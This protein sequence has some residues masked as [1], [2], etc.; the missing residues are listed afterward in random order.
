MRARLRKVG[1]RDSVYAF[2]AFVWGFTFIV[3]YRTLLDEYYPFYRSYFPL[4]QFALVIFAVAFVSAALYRQQQTHHTRR[5]VFS[6]ITTA[7]GLSLIFVAYH[8]FGPQNALLIFPVP[9]SFISLFIWYELSRY[10]FF[11]QS[12]KIFLISG[13]LVALYAARY[14]EHPYIAPALAFLS[15][16]LA[17]FQ[18]PRKWETPH[19]RLVNL[20][21]LIDLLRY[22]FLAHA[23][24]AA[25]GQNRSHLLLVML[26][27]AIGLVIPQLI[28]LFQASRP[29]IQNGLLILPTIFIVLAALFNFIHYSYWGAVAYAGLAI[30][31]SI[32]FLKAHEVYLRREKLVAGFAL[33]M[34]IMAYYIATEWLQIISGAFIVFVLSG[35]LIYVAK[36]W[37]KAITA[38]FA[39]A[40]LTWI[41]SVQWKY[42]NSV[43]REFLKPPVVQTHKPVLPDSGLL[44]TILG[45]QKATGRSVFTNV[46]PDELLDGPAWKNEKIVSRDANPTLLVSQLAYS[47]YLRKRNR[48]YI[49]DEK[50]LGVYSEPGALVQLR[51]LLEKFGNCD[52]YVA[53]KGTLRSVKNLS[54]I[55]Q[56]DPRLV[57]NLT[58]DDAAKLLSLARAEKKIDLIA[59]AQA[60]YEQVNGFYKDDPVFL[61]ELASL[62]AARGQIDRQIEILNA[63]ISLRK[64]NITY[65]RKLLM[66][67]YAIRNERKKSAAIAYELLALGD[68]SPLALYAFL[69]KLFSEPFDRYEIQSLYNRLTAYQPRTD[70]E[71][72]K[73]AGLKRSMEDQLKQNPTYDR[74]FHDENHRQEYITFP[75]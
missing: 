45:L 60:L 27:C 28:R 42:S 12:A 26:I 59:E 63:L 1:F 67:L 58:A 48:I 74:K 50:S 52:F 73:F 23:F 6:V 31:E 53:D 19:E 18:K 51:Y 46:L 7:A 35:I 5:F 22:L 30:W 16:L 11:Y 49:M 40:T 8:Y 75:E 56:T 24:H 62:A 4:S 20:R 33:A 13:V 65:D 34:A 70:L 64:D 9:L 39:A 10:G 68:E 72:I 15:I 3:F 44:L 54:Q 25:L 21:Q 41:V 66:E 61:R 17:R 69:Q 32:Y 38:L 43:T 29:H 57:N 36:N 71:G 14:V 2:A 55:M 37:R 47:C